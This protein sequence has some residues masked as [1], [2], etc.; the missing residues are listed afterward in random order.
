MRRSSLKESADAGEGL[1][2]NGGPEAVVEGGA[3]G[4]RDGGA[5]REEIEEVP[6]G[7]ERWSMAIVSTAIC[8]ALC[9]QRKFCLRM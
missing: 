2:V 6:G 5:Q 8:G 3:D 1:A 9:S 4:R 7:C